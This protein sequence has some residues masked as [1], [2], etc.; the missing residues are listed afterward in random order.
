MEPRFVELLVRGGVVT[1]DQL[2]EAQ[3]KEREN[4]SSITREIVRLGYTSEQILGEFLAKQF[5]IETVDHPTDRQIESIIREID[6]AWYNNPF[7]PGPP[8]AALK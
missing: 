1:R 5:G 3:K 7:R 8:P 2:S 6:G 4:G